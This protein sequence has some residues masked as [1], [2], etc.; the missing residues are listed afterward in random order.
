MERKKIAMIVLVETER[1]DS[2]IQ[3]SNFSPNISPYLRFLWN[4]SANNLT[5]VFYELKARR[6][7]GIS[8]IS[9]FK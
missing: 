3:W 8:D 5:K 7:I 6:S 4:N 2:T 9:I 1:P